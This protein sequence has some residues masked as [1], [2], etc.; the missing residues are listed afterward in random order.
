M[1][2][3]NI[4]RSAACLFVLVLV[5]SVH[6][7]LKSTDGSLTTNPSIP[8]LKTILRDRVISEDFSGS[9]LVAM[10]NQIVLSEGFG[11][12]NLEKQIKNTP[13]TQFAI[14][15]IT[16]IFTAAAI[17]KLAED[18]K[19][20]LSQP[21]SQYIL[22]NSAI[23][24]GQMPE[25]AHKVT[26]QDLLTHRSGLEEY[27]V[28]PEFNQ[29]YKQIHSPD[30][31][32]QFFV[33]YPIKFE[34]GIQFDYNGSGYNLLGLII[35]SMTKDNY[36]KFLN[37]E[38]FKPLHMDSS[39]APRHFLSP[40][41][42]HYSHLAEG[43]IPDV[44]QNPTYAGEINMSTSFA[45]AGILSTTKN[46]FDWTLALFQGKVIS[47]HFL[48]QMLTPYAKTDA[49]DTW[50]GYSFFINKQDP[51][52]PVYYHLGQIKGYDSLLSYEPERGIC[53]IILSNIMDGKTYDLADPLYQLVA[54]KLPMYSY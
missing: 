19:L 42:D 45:E 4:F 15:S 48:D 32:A 33:N 31:L 12:A 41:L 26:V 14:G 35:E 44:D 37:I 21:I 49:K 3:F 53:I 11:Y 1:F 2:M 47:F 40:L 29:F 34:P 27:T 24:S 38:F 7:F 25:W 51:Q 23:W 28:L 54:D 5:F 52:H 10:H 36:A 46:L 43:Y 16:K 39:F 50:M 9:V 6:Q 13:E 18:G 8:A 30:E 20:D 22:E 17:L